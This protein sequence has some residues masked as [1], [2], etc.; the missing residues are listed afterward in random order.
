MLKNLRYG[1]ESLKLSLQANGFSALLLLFSN[2]YENTFSHFSQDNLPMI[3]KIC[4]NE[5]CLILYCLSC[6]TGFKREL[7]MAHTTF[8]V[9]NI[10][11]FEQRL[12][13]NIYNDLQIILPSRN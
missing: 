10:Y 3:K 7:S 11:N 2:I 4:T 8:I 9:G 5:P 13:G 12:S 6:L 1:W